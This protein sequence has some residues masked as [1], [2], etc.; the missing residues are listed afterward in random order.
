MGPTAGL[1]WAKALQ[2][3]RAYLE[4]I[5]KPF[6]PSLSDRV[7]PLSHVLDRWRLRGTGGAGGATHVS[8][9]FSLK[10]LGCW[11][12]R[13]GSRR[14]QWGRWR[15]WRRL[16]RRVRRCWRWSQCC[17]RLRQRRL[18]RCCCSCCCWRCCWRRCWW[19]RGWLV[20]LGLGVAVGQRQPPVLLV[21]TAMMV[22]VVVMVVIGLARRVR[23]HRREPVG[24]RLGVLDVPIALVVRVG[25]DAWRRRRRRCRQQ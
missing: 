6:S 22:V 14:R 9:S 1:A 8:F 5:P 25:H 7:Q 23:E 10:T 19:R 11:C 16:G 17:R 15:R 2:S 4:G 18:H 12:W 24:E 13:L 21:A 3:A 20:G